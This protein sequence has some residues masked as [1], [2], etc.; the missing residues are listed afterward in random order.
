MPEVGLR[1]RDLTVHRGRRPV[2]HGVAFEA[3]HG[4]LTAILGPNGAGKTTLLKACAGLVRFDGRVEI[5]GRSLESVPRDLRARMLAYVPQHSALESDLPVE[6]VVAQ[7]RYAFGELGRPGARARLRVADAMDRTDVTHLA[8]RPFT[9]LSFGERR[10]VLLARGLA[11]GAR[12]LLL[13]EPT[14]SLDVAH[15]LSLHALLRSLAHDGYCVAAV[16]HPLDE[17]ARFCDRAALLVDGRVACH[18]PVN[19]VIAA[20]PVRAVYGVTMRSGGATAFDL[21]EEVLQ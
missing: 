7:G 10:R 3:R 17:A 9:Q 2:L 16:L 15:V 8:S 4:E 20:G 6:R 13:D 21:P 14:A 11:T 5:A 19:E 18:G 12:I 1:A